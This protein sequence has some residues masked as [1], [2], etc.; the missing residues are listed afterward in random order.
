MLVVVSFLQSHLLG[1]LKINWTQKG[2]YLGLFGH[3]GDRYFLPDIPLVVKLGAV[4]VFVT[5]PEGIKTTFEPQNVVRYL[6]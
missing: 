2:P 4:L 1:L 5:Y 3:F 6:Q